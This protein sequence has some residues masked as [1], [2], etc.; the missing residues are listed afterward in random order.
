MLKLDVHSYTSRNWAYICKIT[1][2]MVLWFMWEDETPP[3][4]KVRKKTK[5]LLLL[6]DKSYIYVICIYWWYLMP[7]I[8]SMRRMDNEQ[9]II[10]K[11]HH[12]NLLGFYF[13]SIYKS[14]YNNITY[15]SHIVLAQSIG[16][17]GQ[18][19]RQ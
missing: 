9:K 17:N 19:F 1:K 15:V 11:K 13:H 4:N 6:K 18:R 10:H 7:L 12:W 8:T 3:K 5:F 14:Q 2:H 16:H